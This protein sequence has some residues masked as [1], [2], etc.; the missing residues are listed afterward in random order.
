M[1]F[2]LNFLFEFTRLGKTWGLRG[3]G[4]RN[5]LVL[6]YEKEWTTFNIFILLLVFCFFYIGV[7]EK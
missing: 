2:F 6:K 7:I 4:G 1:F 5:M 3:V